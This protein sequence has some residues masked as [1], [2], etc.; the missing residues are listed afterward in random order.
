[1]AETLRVDKWLWYARFFKTRS[2][3]A[4]IVQSGIR[5]NQTKVTKAH[6]A[7]KPGDVLTFQKEEDVRVIEVVALGESRRPFQE[8]KMLYT[9]LQPPAPK[10]RQPKQAVFEIREEGAG[11]PTKRDR[12]KTDELKGL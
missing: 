10:I 2:L 4:K 9:D 5:I 7:L 1:M 8:A 11:R 12:R 3:A 6:H